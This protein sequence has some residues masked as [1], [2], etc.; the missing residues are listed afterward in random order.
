MQTAK[1]PVIKKIKDEVFTS[2]NVWKAHQPKC[3]GGHYFIPAF[4]AQ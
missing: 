3:T 4:V 1:P 2:M